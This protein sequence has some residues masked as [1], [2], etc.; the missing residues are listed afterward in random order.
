[1]IR[2]SQK[3]Q[4][5]RAQALLALGVLLSASMGI[6]FA[7]YTIDWYTVD[8]GGLTFSTGGNYELSGTVG[9]PDAG[10]MTGGTYT[11]TGGFWFGQMPGDCDYDG[12]VDLDDF[13]D[14]EACL[15]GPGGGLGPDCNCFDLDGSG[16]VDLGDFAVFQEAFTG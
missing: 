5:A 8:G 6:A 9:Q 1:V 12:D 13:A 7:D 10:E 14:F 16:D 2:Y 3:T 4:S 15:L 11:L